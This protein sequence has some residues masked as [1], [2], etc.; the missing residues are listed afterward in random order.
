MNANGT[1]YHHWC[2]DDAPP[3]FDPNPNWDGR[4]CHTW[5]FSGAGVVDDQGHPLQASTVPKGP[6]FNC[7]LFWC[8][9][10]PHS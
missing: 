4:V 8:P 10:P 2:P 6:P 3:L 5:R 9:V 1:L 7:G